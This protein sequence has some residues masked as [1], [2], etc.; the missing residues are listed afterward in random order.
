MENNKSEAP[1]QS[2]AEWQSRGGNVGMLALNG[3]KS[4]MRGLSG[5]FRVTNTDNNSRRNAKRQGK[6]SEKWSRENQKLRIRNS[7]L[8]ILWVFDF[9]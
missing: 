5:R 3:R 1:V 4:R 8:L 6:E 7:K 9:S 2:S